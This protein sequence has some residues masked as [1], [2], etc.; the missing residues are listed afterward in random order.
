MQDCADME[1][2]DWLAASLQSLACPAS[3]S[4]DHSLS[5]MQSA[6]PLP[7]LDPY[8][9]DSSPYDTREPSPVAQPHVNSRYFLPASSS[10]LTPANKTSPRRQEQNRAAYVST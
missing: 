8:S 4:W 3:T 6:V 2:W 5:G 10:S 9:L 1:A 7:Y